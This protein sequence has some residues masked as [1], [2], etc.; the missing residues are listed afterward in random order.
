MGTLG[1]C[2]C[3]LFP[4]FSSYNSPD[5]SLYSC[6]FFQLLLK[7]Y[8]QSIFFFTF[9]ELYE[10]ILPGLVIDILKSISLWVG[11]QRCVCVCVWVP[12][13]QWSW[14]RKLDITSINS[15]SL[16]FSIS[17]KTTFFPCGLAYFVHFIY[18]KSYT[19]WYF[20]LAFVT[21]HNVFYVIASINTLFLFLPNNIS[22]CE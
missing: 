20:G 2:F 5:S 9:E 11:L 7:P 1:N 10:L 13:I 19:V 18:K 3:Y 14:H 22:L 6:S 4:L 17:W 8:R 16:F 15:H 12:M 21:W